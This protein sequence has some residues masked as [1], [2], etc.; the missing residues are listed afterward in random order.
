MH[1]KFGDDPAT[2]IVFIRP[3]VLGAFG[4]VGAE[5]RLTANYLANPGRTPLKIS[6][7]RQHDFR[8]N[9]LAP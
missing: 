1:T 6:G 3:Y 5:K 9:I 8:Q 7:S 2:I 4:G